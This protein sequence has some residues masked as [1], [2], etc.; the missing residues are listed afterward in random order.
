MSGTT[1]LAICTGGLIL[2]AT[3]AWVV[4]DALSQL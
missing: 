1:V 3:A 2:M 4:F